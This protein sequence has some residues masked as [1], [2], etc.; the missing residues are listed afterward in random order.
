MSSKRPPAISGVT[1]SA[2]AAIASVYP[3]IAA[4]GVGCGLGKLY[5]SIPVRIGGVKLSNL[6]F[7][8]P[9]APIAA[10]IYLLQK[11]F[12][13]RYLLTNRAL[14]KWK[15]LGSERVASVN[16]ADIGDV[17]IRQDPGQVFYRAADLY[18]VNKAGDRIMS[19]PGVPYA[20]VFRQTILEARDARQQVAASLDTIRAR[21]AV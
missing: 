16:L 9:T 6:L 10:L 17:V 8:L 11:A 18:V 14:Q 7:V 4:T 21:P 1:S 2:E 19:L 5:N 15:S 3:S 20:D 12:G 13:T